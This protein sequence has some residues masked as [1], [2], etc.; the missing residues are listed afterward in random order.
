MGQDG[1]KGPPGRTEYCHN[2]HRQSCATG[3]IGAPGLQGSPGDRG[4]K[5]HIGHKGE[6]G[7]EGPIGAT[8]RRGRSGRT[9]SRGLLT[10]I[11]CRSQRTRYVRPN[12]FKNRKHK[13][14]CNEDKLEFLRGFF[15][16][17]RGEKI[18][19]HYRCCWF[20]SAF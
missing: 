14:S 12:R 2:Y 7:D 13:F 5:G 17:T 4:K 8:G 10:Q 15:I 6:I 16:E 19:Y 11:E 18:R 20:I 1:P 9:G 3:N